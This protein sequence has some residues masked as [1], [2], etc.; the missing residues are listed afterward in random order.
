MGLGGSVKIL[1]PSGAN[2]ILTCSRF[3]IP[4]VSDA[5]GNAGIQFF[6]AAADYNWRP[7]TIDPVTNAVTM[8]SFNGLVQGLSIPFPY[9][10]ASRLQGAT[11]R[12]LPTS[13]LVNQS[14]VTFCAKSAPIT[15]AITGGPVLWAPAVASFLGPKTGYAP[16]VSGIECVANVMD[17]RAEWLVPQ[18]QSA[19]DLN[20]VANA[21]DFGAFESVWMSF[22]GVPPSQTI[23]YVSVCMCWEYTMATDPAGPFGPYTA[24][25]VMGQQ[26]PAV[27]EAVAS[28]VR[29][30]VAEKS[31]NSG[32]LIGT[33]KSGSTVAPMLAGA[34]LGVLES[35]PWMS[36]TLSSFLGGG[37]AGA[38]MLGPSMTALE[39]DL[40]SETLFGGAAMAA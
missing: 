2:T 7:A 28:V 34:L 1:G 36:E 31:A 19:A 13:S 11:Y 24:A 32:G 29:Q 30:V 6:P 10:A 8:G 21:V 5:N 9:Q 20:Q 17:P 33:L 35:N 22:L 15:V 4:V 27:P 39:P 14:G 23:G 38:P 18:S 12:F 16:F 3:I 37:V 26:T 40:Y 25:I